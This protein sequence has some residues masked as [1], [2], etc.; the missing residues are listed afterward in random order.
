MVLFNMVVFGSLHTQQPSFGPTCCL[1][2]RW[3]S[4]Q[5]L[6]NSHIPDVVVELL[7]ASMYLM[8]APYRPSQMP[9]VAFLRLLESFARGHWNTDPFIVNF[10]NE[11]S[12][13]Y[14]AIS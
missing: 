7:V 2:K 13:K 14:L 11:M 5:L 10:N 1:A 4:A 8:P 6:D 12:S 3:L 9:Q